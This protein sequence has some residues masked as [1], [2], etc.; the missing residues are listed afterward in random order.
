MTP[1][2]VAALQAENVRLQ[3]ALTA[4]NERWDTMQA[5]LRQFKAEYDAV[6]VKHAAVMVDLVAIRK[7]HAAKR[8]FK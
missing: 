8:K 1:D 3:A 4:A 5:Q 6:D 2:E 7:E